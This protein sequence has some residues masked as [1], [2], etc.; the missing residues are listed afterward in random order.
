MIKAGFS[1]LKRPQRHTVDFK[2][3]HMYIGRLE[4]LLIRKTNI[5]KIREVRSEGQSSRSN[6]G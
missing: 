3:I 1:R 6:M 2:I 5:C 4:A